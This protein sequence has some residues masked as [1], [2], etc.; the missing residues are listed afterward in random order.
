MDVD[1]ILKYISEHPELV[2]SIISYTRKSRLWLAKLRSKR[3]KEIDSFV[4]GYYLPRLV[5]A[6]GLDDSAFIEDPMLF[7]RN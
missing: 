5:L 3:S 2:F 7:A 6:R 4:L 1:A